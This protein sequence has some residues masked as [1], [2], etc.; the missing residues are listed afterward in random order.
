MALSSETLRARYQDPND[1]A[2]E[3]EPLRPSLDPSGIGSP[4]EA[5]RL[6][7]S[8]AAIAHRAPRARS[9]GPTIE[10]VREPAGGN[11]MT[12]RFEIRVPPGQGPC[13]AIATEFPRL[14][15]LVARLFPL[16]DGLVVE[17]VQVR[18]DLSD[19]SI[20]HRILKLAAGFLIEVL[21]DSDRLLTFRTTVRGG[22]VIETLQALGTA[23]VLPIR[24]TGNTMSLTVMTPRTKIQELYARFKSAGL[25]ILIGGITGRRSKSR[26]PGSSLTPRQLECY[27]IA[28]SAGYWDT[29]RRTTLTR[30]AEILQVSKSTLS[31]TLAA[32]ERK[33]LKEGANPDGF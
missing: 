2:T 3:T 5:T 15:V 9:C 28:R 19:P 22:S 20:G 33:V 18:G 25:H 30:M 14:D 11:V 6:G 29:P 26:N 8:R 17:D 13:A 12:V 4:G 27:R 16:G 32:V 23:P 21:E 24:V 1:F 10:V 7:R 31:E